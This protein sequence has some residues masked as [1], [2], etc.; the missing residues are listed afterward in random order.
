LQRCPNSVK[1]QLEHLEC[2]CESKTKS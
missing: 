2:E 1:N